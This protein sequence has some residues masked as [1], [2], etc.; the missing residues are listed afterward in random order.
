MTTKPK[1]KPKAK[2][3]RGRPAKDYPTIPDTFEAVVEALV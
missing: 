1:A 3:P 2:R